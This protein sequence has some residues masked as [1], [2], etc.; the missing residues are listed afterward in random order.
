MKQAFKVQAREIIRSAKRQGITL[1]RWPES[2]LTTEVCATAVI[3]GELE[4]H[5]IYAPNRI[6]NLLNMPEENILALSYGFEGYTVVPDY[7]RKNRYYKVG[8]RVAQM[9]GLP[10]HES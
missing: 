2:N 3:R 8:Q 1:T 4:G 7:I 5:T 10:I 9:A 6:A